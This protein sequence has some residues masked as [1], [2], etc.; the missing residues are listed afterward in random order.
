MELLPHKCLLEQ[1]KYDDLD[2]IVSDITGGKG[3]NE[4]DT[5]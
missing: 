3:Q 1:I 4:V 2:G 5:F